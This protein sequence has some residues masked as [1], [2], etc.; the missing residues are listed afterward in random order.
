MGPQRTRQLRDALLHLSDDYRTGEKFNRSWGVSGYVPVDASSYEAIAQ[1]LEEE[2]DEL[3]EN[4]P[5]AGQRAASAGDHALTAPDVDLAS[6]LRTLLHADWIEPLVDWCK[7][8]F[9]K[10]STCRETTA[11]ASQ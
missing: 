5:L 3:P 8:S 9:R 11:A 2:R 7:F 6:R 10:T 1:L 4:S